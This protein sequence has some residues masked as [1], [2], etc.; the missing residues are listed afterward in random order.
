[1]NYEQMWLELKSTIQ[2]EACLKLTGAH[3]D[4]GRI[5][6]CAKDKG[7]C[8]IA[9]RILDMANS[10][11]DECYKNPQKQTKVLLEDILHLFVPGLLGNN[12]IVIYITNTNN[13]IYQIYNT[14]KYR[15]L[16]QNKNLTDYSVLK[17]EAEC[18]DIIIYATYTGVH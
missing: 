3:Q 7:R 18:D 5:V 14:D 2:R 17:I 13:E 16:K 1:M 11:E 6:D 4:G 12:Q 10:I 9:Q 8:E 15:E